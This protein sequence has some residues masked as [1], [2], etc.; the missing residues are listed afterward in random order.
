[1]EQILSKTNYQIAFIERFES[2]GRG[3]KS[4]ELNMSEVCA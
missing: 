3:E 4:K 1:L 2:E